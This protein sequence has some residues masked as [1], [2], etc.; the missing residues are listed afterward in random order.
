MCDRPTIM[1]APKHCCPFLR[2]H[3]RFVCTLAD[4]LLTVPAA[5]PSQSDGPPKDVPPPTPIHF[6]LCRPAGAVPVR[7]DSAGPGSG[8]AL[9]AGSQSC[10]PSP[11][12][13]TLLQALVRPADQVQVSHL[14]ALG[15][16]VRPD[17]PLS[18]VIPSPAREDWSLPP[19]D[20]WDTLSR[21][22]TIDLS[23]D[24][25]SRS[26]LC[27]GKLTPGPTK[28][29]D[30]RQALLTE[31]D[32]AFQAVR[33][34]TPRPGEQYV[35]LG[36]CHDFF[37]NLEALTSFWDDT[38]IAHSK[39]TSNGPSKTEG[40][41]QE[42]AEKPAED[43]LH[44]PFY[45]TSAGSAMPPPF[46]TNLLSSFVKLV[47]YDFN[48]NIMSKQEPRLYITSPSS[49]SSPSKPRRTQFFSGCTMIYR[50]PLD[51][52]SAKRGIVE[53]PIAAVSPRH[54]TAFPPL[55]REREAV[56]DLSKEIIA[57]L[58]TAQ[59]RARQGK[60]ENRI[61]KDAWWTTRRRWGG[62]SGGPIGKEVELLEAKEVVGEEEGSPSSPPTSVS[63]SRPHVSASRLSPLGS[64]SRYNRPIPPSLASSSS[65]SSPAP[66]RMQ[67]CASLS[68]SGGGTGTVPP[69]KRARTSLAIYDAYRMVRPP[70]LQ[71]DPK[72][73]HEAI[74]R[75]R[76]V[77]YDD[78]FVISSLFHHISVLRV[79]VPDRLLAVLDGNE[80]EEDDKEGRSGSRRAHVEVYRTRWFDFFVAEDRLE[81][82]K[83]IWAVMAYAMREVPMDTG[84]P[85]TTPAQGQNGSSSGA[86]ASSGAGQQGERM[87]VHDTKIGP[88]GA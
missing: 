4:S 81:A 33:R 24:S 1:P 39:E 76:G 50:M 52:D 82:M 74:G 48:C 45:R 78:V 41:H 72:T 55:V 49:S 7:P 51:R 46:R 40:E 11:H 42:P 8:P 25:E 21:E 57:A 67:E 14:E 20:H 58:I 9:G 65:S 10:Q 37:R 83:T 28:Y 84:P 53:G 22:D 36:Y 77:D 61:G 19:F 85:T 80:E 44:A 3:P 60:V 6:P 12:L 27:N 70:S 15:V 62:G 59:H 87:E 71:W 86:G 18:Q 68:G 79:R 88:A 23:R 16:V 54:A 38:S 43:D 5:P 75:Q 26:K 32:R 35:R 29:V 63:S 13:T 69:S 66:S 56:V 30:L 73:R 34:V 17:A 47:T 31:N 64:R 2:H